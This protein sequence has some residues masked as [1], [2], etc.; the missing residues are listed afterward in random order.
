M[1]EQDQ[2]RQY[3]EACYYNLEK[4]RDSGDEAAINAILLMIERF[5]AM[6]EQ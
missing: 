5:E 3:I 1:N 6:V 2:I 4:Y